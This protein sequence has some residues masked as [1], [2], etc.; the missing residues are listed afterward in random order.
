MPKRYEPPGRKSILQKVSS[1]PRGPNQCARCSLSVQALKT[2]LRGAS[3]TRVMR[4]ILSAG[5]GPALSPA[6]I[7][8]LLAVGSFRS[9]FLVANLCAGAV[10]VRQI[11]LEPGKRQVPADHHRF[12]LFKSSP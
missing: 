11:L 8:A 4:S 9:V 12:E 1:K 2:R 7:T 10:D 6:D 3:K 5:A